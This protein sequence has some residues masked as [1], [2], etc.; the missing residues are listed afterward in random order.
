A[1]E[2]RLARGETD[3]ARAYLEK[4]IALAPQSPEAQLAYGRDLALLGEE[5]HAERAFQRAAELD[6]RSDR[7]FD[8]LAQLHAHDPARAAKLLGQAG[9]RAEAGL[10][11]RRAASHYARATQADPHSGALGRERLARL[12]GRLG[13]AEQARA[14]WR[15]SLDTD[16]PTPARLLG[17]AEAASA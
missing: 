5:A 15:E 7:A 4:A 3:A 11:L 6:P 12:Y 13:E 16:G 14:A 10:E 1:G 2:I 17:A 9:E 8:E